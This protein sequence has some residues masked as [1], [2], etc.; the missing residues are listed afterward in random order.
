MH[1]RARFGAG[2]LTGEINRWLVLTLKIDALW[3][4][5]EFIHRIRARQC[6]APTRNI[7][8]LDWM[9]YSLTSLENLY[10][11]V[12]PVEADLLKNGEYAALPLTRFTSK[13]PSA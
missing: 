2:R 7:A 3:H 6:R 10:V 1:D 12:N 8:L 9:R 5:N 11:N 13:F 4:N